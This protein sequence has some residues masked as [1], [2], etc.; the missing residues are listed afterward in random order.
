[1]APFGIAVSLI[2]PGPVPTAFGSTAVGT[3][4]VPSSV[5]A[6]GPY[7]DFKH[8]LAA[9]YASSYGGRRG[10][11]L[12]SSPERVAKVIVKAAEASWP[13]ARYV[14]GPVAHALVTSRRLLP[15]RA[16]DALLRSSFPTP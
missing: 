6:A 10:R 2:E 4:D 8:R 12:A 14:V 13:R 16:F 5:G 1:V 3:L 7:D 9:A 11:L 15:D